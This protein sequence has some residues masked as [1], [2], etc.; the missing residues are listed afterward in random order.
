MHKRLLTVVAALLAWAIFVDTIPI[1]RVVPL[2]KP[3][4]RL[5][6]KVGGW[7]GTSVELTGD[8]LKEL[9]VTDYLSRY[10]QRGA[11][12]VE[13]YVGYYDSQAA[14]RQIHS[15][16]HCL[17]GGGW[18]FSSQKTREVDLAGVGKISLVEAYYEKE[19]ARLLLVYWYRMKDGY[20]TNEYLLKWRMILNSVRYRRNEAT[21]VRFSTLSE[22][23]DGRAFEAVRGFMA[24]FVPRLQEHLPR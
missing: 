8:I 17:P 6:L 19:G 16:K 9:R 20:I 14:G 18:N 7:E 22:G 21:F 3:L 11:D 2:Q 10:Y 15:P 4:S 1:S 5:P 12:Q 23:D 24:D 13:V